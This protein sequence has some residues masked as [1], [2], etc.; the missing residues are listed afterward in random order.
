MAVKRVVIRFK[1]AK[2]FKSWLSKNRAT[3][4]G[5]WI[6]FFRKDSGMPTITY[7][8]ALDEALCQG[9]IDAQANS[10]DSVSWIQRFLP[11]RAKSGWSKR[12][13]LHAKRLIKEGRM[14]AAGLKQIEAAKKDGRWKGAYDSPRNAKPPA[15]FLKSSR[16]G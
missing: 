8:E 10:Y 2:E 4:D 12:N 15:D 11:R 5:I 13:T 9:W 14:R 16:Q 7:A 1:S 3:P 6:R